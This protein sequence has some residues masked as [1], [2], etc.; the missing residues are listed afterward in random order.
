MRIRRYAPR[1]RPPDPAAPPIHFRCGQAAGL[2]RFGTGRP[3]TAETPAALTLIRRNSLRAVRP[4]GG[5]RVTMR[6]GVPGSAVTPA[7]RLHLMAWR[8]AAAGPPG[9]AVNGA[10]PWRDRGRYPA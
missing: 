2:G 4:R 1:G 3:A 8:A 6:P 5:P 9:T 10:S 7:G